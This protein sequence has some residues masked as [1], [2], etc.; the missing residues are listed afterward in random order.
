MPSILLSRWTASVSIPDNRCVLGLVGVCRVRSSIMGADFFMDEL[1]VLGRLRDDE[2]RKHYRLLKG[3]R[4]LYGLLEDLTSARVD[5]P[6]E[7]LDISGGGVRLL[8]ERRLPGG[9]QVLLELE[10]PG[11]RVV[12]GDWQPSDNDDDLGVLRVVAQV[13]WTALDTVRKGKFQTGLRFTGQVK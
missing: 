2:R 4:I 9:S 3:Y 10:I 8:T 13:V 7:L 12:D 1:E 6:A 5:N 11:W